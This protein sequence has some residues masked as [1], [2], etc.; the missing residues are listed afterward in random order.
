MLW[1]SWFE[2]KAFNS[3]YLS[4]VDGHKVFFQEF[5]NPN[6]RPVLVFHGGP[7]GSFKPKHAQDFDLKKYRVIGF[8]QRGGGKSLPMGQWNKNTSTDIINDAERLLKHLKIFDKLIVKGPSWGAAM[9]LKFAEAFPKQVRALILNSVFLADKDAEKWE[10]EDAAYFYPDV[11][12]KIKEGVSE[13]EN[14]PSYYAQMICSGERE[15]QQYAI[16]RYGMYERLRSAL[17]P[18][19]ELQEVTEESLAQNRIFIMYAAKKFYL[20]ENEI[21]KNIKKISKIPTL[22]VHNRLDFVCPLKG[23]YR[24]HKAMPNSKLVIVPDMGHGS[25]M[26]FKT[27]RQETKNFLKQNDF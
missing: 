17:N 1:D 23:A 5:G 9:A 24:L 13:W 8:D 26:L 12:D 27:L 20:K 2:P 18:Q 7:G 6:G 21:F 16:T 25:K 11:L 3:G 15:K 14:I 19:F 4:E 22:I 10:E